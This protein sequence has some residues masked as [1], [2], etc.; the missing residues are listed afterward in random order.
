MAFEQIVAW[1]NQNTGFMMGALTALY[2]VFTAWIVWESR[3]TN[4]LQAAAI[5][6]ATELENSRSRPYLIFHIDT[7][8]KTYSDYDAS[9]HFVAS[10]SNVGRTSAHNIRITTN[11][12]FSPPVGYGEGNALKYRTPAMLADKISMLPPGHT[13]DEELGPTRF[14]Y[15]EFGNKDLKFRVFMTYCSSTGDHYKDDYVIDLG[16]RTERVG[17]ADAME[18]LRFREVDV[19]SKVSEELGQLNR[20]LN[21]PDRGRLYTSIPID[22]ITKQQR[23]LLANISKQSDA[24]GCIHY[25]LNVHLDGADLMPTCP[26]VSERIRV[27]AFDVEQLCRAGLMIGHYDAGTLFCT[28]SRAASDILRDDGQN[29]D[30]DSR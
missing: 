11:P 4:K 18:Q 27:S 17:S 9:W 10:V 8:M 25:F 29:A 30:G 16:E 20:T 14:L 15:K 13:E 7:K 23:E 24:S 5:R 22:Q 12:D 1:A 3:R 19:L 2:V 26:G 21:A 6:Q 28:L